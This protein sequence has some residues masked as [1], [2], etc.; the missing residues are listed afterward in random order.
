MC[1][2]LPFVGQLSTGKCL[3]SVGY[4]VNAALAV[5][6][7][8]AVH[9]SYLYNFPLSESKTFSGY[10]SIKQNRLVYIKQ[11]LRWVFLFPTVNFATPNQ[12]VCRENFTFCDHY[13]HFIA[14]FA[15]PS[16]HE[17]A[18]SCCT[19][20]LY[21]IFNVSRRKKLFNCR[22]YELLRP[23]YPFVSNDSVVQQ[24]LLPKGSFVFR[25]LC[26]GLLK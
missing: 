24:R 19:S 26:Y 18:L 12:D 23:K 1:H 16:P 11:I 17:I 20:I 13:F 15:A 10:L 7:P 2:P 9:V 14:K 25:E 21:I 3:E 5:T 8:V 22:P 6:S 4:C